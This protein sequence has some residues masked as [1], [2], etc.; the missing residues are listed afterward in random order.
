[1]LSAQDAAAALLVYLDWPGGAVRAW[2]GVGSVTWNAQTWLG[3]G[4]LGS[5]DKIVDSVD[6]ADI[7]VDL[8]FNYLDDTLRNAIIAT[9]PVGRAA[10][11][12]LA[13]VNAAAGTITD[14]Y[15]IFAGFMD[16]VEIEDAGSSGRIVVRLASE[17]ARLNRP[18]YYQLTHAHQQAL[19]PGDLGMEFAPRMDEPIMWGR[20]PLLPLTGPGQPPSTEPYP[21]YNDQFLFPYPQ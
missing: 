4:N 6:R 2:T 9:D 16:R 18:T 10:S 15:E 8:S 7:G 12:Y 20:R 17:L 5:I 14:A 11:V 21:G 1:M 3:V 13:A 19:F